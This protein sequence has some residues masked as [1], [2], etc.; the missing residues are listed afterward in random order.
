ME[1]RL[2]QLLALLDATDPATAGTS[3][4]LPVALRD[5]AALAA[6]MGLAASTS[7]LT[8]QGLR[9]A[10]EALAQRAVLDEHYRA[11]PH[12]R[13][14]VAEIALAT[15]ELDGNPLARRPA[16]IRRAAEQLHAAGVV[17]TPDEILLYA[18]GMAAGAP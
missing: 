6:D 11:H 2:T 5:A 9:A 12:T 1:E 7:D 8:A 17:P 16:L 4:R 18:A 10:L 14:G 13:P 3:V 15:A